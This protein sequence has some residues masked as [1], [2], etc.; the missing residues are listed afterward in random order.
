MSPG[1]YKFMTKKY[2]EEVYLKNVDIWGFLM[3]YFAFLGNK[4][5]RLTR[6]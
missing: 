4:S 3:S 2:F 5:I 1:N 6:G